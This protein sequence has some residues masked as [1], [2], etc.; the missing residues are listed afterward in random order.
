MTTRSV[1][2]AAPLAAAIALQ[3]SPTLAVAAD[4]TP[5]EPPATQLETIEVTGKVDYRYVQKTTSTATRTESDLLDV[6]QAVTV[7]T[8]DLIQDLGIQGMADAVRYVP[9]ISVTQGEGNRDGLVFRGNSSTADLFVD[10]LRDDMQYYRD[11]YNIERIEAFKGP[12]AMI[13]GRGS[14][15]GLLNRVTKVPGWDPARE[16]GFQVGS[17]NKRRLTADLNQPLNDSAAFRVTGVYEDS[18]GFRDGFALSRKGLHPTLSLRPADATLITLGYEVF[19]DER[20]A[21]RGIPSL[22]AAQ[23]F[24][25]TRYPVSTDR[26]TFFGD[27]DGSPASVDVN[28]FT[29]L[30]EHDFGHAFLR[31]RFRYAEYNKFYQNVFPGNVNAAGTTVALSA[32]NNDTQRDNAFNQTD[33]TFDVGTGTLQHRFLIGAEFGRQETANERRSGRFASGQAVCLPGSTA[34]SCLVALTDPNVPLVVDYLHSSAGG[35]GDARN[36]GVTRFAAIYAQDQI[37]LSPQWEAVLGVRFDRFEVDFTDLR[38]GVSPASRDLSS[39]DDLFSPR[40]GLVYKPADDLSFYAS[41]G[42]TYLPR[43]GEQLASLTF[44]T[45]SLDPEEFKNYEIGTKWDITPRLSATAAVYRLGRSNVAVVDPIDPTQMILLSGDSQRTEGMELSLSG[46]ITPAWQVV[47]S[48]TYQDAVITRDVRTSPTSVTPAGTELAQSPRHMAGLWNRFE[49]SER[50]GLGLGAIYR[51][52]SY[53]STSNLVTLR[54]YARYDGAVYYAVNENIDL[55][56][57]VENLFDKAYFPSAHSDSNL[58]PGSPRSYYLSARF[59]F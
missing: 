41:Y 18:E 56:L 15:G 52:R 32:Y 47:A 51:S 30:I 38:N 19:R 46:D 14:P 26:E 54:S 12:N 55:Q 3:L 53:A 1:L 39:S 23:A 7:I 4:Q 9:G 10:G 29:A 59:G 35:T 49:L 27:P 2:R 48:Y 42:V 45:Q 22:S 24:N 6:P 43:S 5:S 28:A 8:Q 13:F 11:T 34:T 16:V 33:L 21:D 50:W 31:N 44:G 36:T 37:T 57:N 17:W 58:T 40:A 25:G 20:T